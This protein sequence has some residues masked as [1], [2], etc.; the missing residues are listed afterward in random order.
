MHFRLIG[1]ALGALVAVLGL[2]MATAIP[3]SLYYGDGAHAGLALAV[4][5]CLAVGTVVFLF[6]R[7]HDAD[8][9]LRDGF[10]I[11]TLT[12]LLAGF[13]GAFP[14]W[15]TGVLP[16]FLDALFESVSGFTTTGS[17]VLTD[18]EQVPPSVLYWRS[19]T[20]W[21]GG[22]GIIVLSVAILP[23]LG[24]GGMAMFKAEVPSPVVDKLKPTVAETAKT[25]WKV[26]VF[27]SVVE[28]IL[29]YV[30]GMDL[31][32]A[33]CHTFATLATGGFSTKNLSIGYYQSVPIQAIIT[34]FML[35]AGV[36]FTLHYQARRLNFRAYWNS[37]EFRL[38]MLI[39]F[40]VA[41]FITWNVWK[42]NYD[43]LGEAV[44]HSTFQTASMMSTTGYGT[45]N[46][47][48]WPQVCQWVLLTLMFMGGCAGSTGGGIKCMR[49][50][51]LFKHVFREL[52]LLI[53]PR[54]VIP[55]KIDRKAI[56]THIVNSV[57]AFIGLYL[58][59][60]AVSTLLLVG[61]SLDPIT[62]LSASTATLSNIG[63]GLGKVGAMDHYAWISWPGK[64]ILIFNMLV[65]RLEL[66]TVLVL[67]VPG[68]WRR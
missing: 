22:M 43:G 36:S 29:L 9:G 14:F 37:L 19:L 32:D 3:W 48:E 2:C 58:G 62:A 60:W 66:Y 59:V 21:L 5:L 35:V 25:L 7:D 47:E 12:W 31:F 11:V 46:W 44:L 63:P 24:V 34:V 49:L 39:F 40:F 52:R 13:F 26:Y 61:L 50:I 15:V 42:T 4:V 67:M 57:L 28:V 65:G 27:F 6:S 64:C 51:I 45:A 68:F 20:Q 38:Y 55:V 41:A 1:E 53:H 10:V 54:A 30:A 56:P 17:T 33:L 18:I 23:L 16:N 8:F